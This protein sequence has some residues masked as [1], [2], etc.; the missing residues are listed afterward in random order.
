MMGNSHKYFGIR[1]SLS[2]S[3][4]PDIVNLVEVFSFSTL[5]IASKDTENQGNM[6]R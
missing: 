6:E 4:F 3:R 1:E 5:A 2:A